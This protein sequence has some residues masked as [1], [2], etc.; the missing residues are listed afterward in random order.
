MRIA[1]NVND[2]ERVASIAAGAMLVAYG[3]KQRERKMGSATTTGV[4]L[5]ARGLTG[6]CPVNAVTGRERRRDD[7]REALRGS[8][9][10]RVEETI[11]INRT[12]AELYRF[13]RNLGNL[14]LFMKTIERV[15]VIDSCRSHWV[16]RGPAGMRVE[17]DA[18]VI[19]EIEP[20]LIG[21]RS[22]RGSDVASAGSVHF[23]PGPRGGTELQVTMQYAP[24]AG[25]LGAS[26]AWMMGQSP[27]TQLREDL[28]QLKQI[29]ETG[30]T[31]KTTG[32]PS[33]HRSAIGRVVTA[34]RSA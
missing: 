14:P 22:L 33:G 3:M 24:P 18:E 13:W 20:E 11:S 15:D 23:K 26:V 34:R 1:R 27:A 16:A 17:W 6:F 8:R 10:I 5:L 29:L 21:W 28:R 2:W 7:S 4:G 19:N 25:K 9:G 32:Q 31:P 12:P 30:E